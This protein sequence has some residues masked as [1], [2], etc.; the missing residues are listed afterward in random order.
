V[1]RGLPNNVTTDMD[2]ELWRTA[3]ILRD[4]PE[5]ASLFRGTA[6]KE[7]ARRYAEG[8]LP[9]TAQRALRRFLDSYGHRAVAEIDLGA[10]RW[11]DDPTHIVNVLAN[12]LRL[13]DPEL[14]PDRQFARAAGEA[15][16]MAAELARRAG[17]PRRLRGRAVAYGLRRAR[18][19][20]GMREQPKFAFILVL[21]GLRDQVRRVGEDLAAAGR[22]DEPEDVFFLDLTEARVGVRGADLHEIV[23]G[24]RRTYE[25]EMRRRHIPR[26]LLSDGTDV[27]AAIA[28][29]AGASPGATQLPPGTLA[30]APASA[31][32]VTARARVVLDPSSAHLE[33][34]EILVAP[35][36]DPGWT[37]LFL[38]AGGLVMEMGG[39]MSHGAVVAREYGLPAVVGVPDA[40][41][42]IRTGQ[43]ITVDGAAGTVT[44][45]AEP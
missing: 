41:T 25:H 32:S 11:S 14:A 26:L 9:A 7:I 29:E 12:Y 13:G 33:P 44:T 16:A 27:E 15:E 19:A 28:A 18:D 22:I 23:T 30:G 34:G 24:R 8:S 20:A 1:L 39:A 40:T 6:P 45:E 3:T 31:G 35:S 43:T 2:L 36:T 5:S 4:D 21:A 37:P 10:P 38:T 17:A 42:K